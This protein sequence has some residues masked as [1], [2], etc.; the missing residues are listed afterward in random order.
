MTSR[1]SQVSVLAPVLFDIS[2][3]DMKEM[4]E[5]PLVKFAGDTK[6]RGPVNM[7]NKRAAIQ[8]DLARLE[9]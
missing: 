5:C 2:I 7:L 8:K 4:T 3:S 1:A 9:E 6:S